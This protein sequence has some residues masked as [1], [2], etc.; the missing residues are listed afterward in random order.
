MI[1]GDRFVAG[2]QTGAAVDMAVLNSTA[3]A[4]HASMNGEY[5]NNFKHSCAAIGQAVSKPF[6]VA[7]AFCTKDTPPIGEYTSYYNKEGLSGVPEFISNLP[8]NERGH[9]RLDA[10]Y[11]ARA[12]VILTRAEAA[13]LFWQDGKVLES[14]GKNMEASMRRQNAEV[15]GAVA[16]LKKEPSRPELPVEQEEM[17]ITSGLPAGLGKAKAQ[18]RGA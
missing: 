18:E 11:K 3:A 6:R 14:M 12:D 8:F 17:E 7:A 2:S 16:W 10:E 4:K 5:L 9:Y 15:E 1:L 13:K